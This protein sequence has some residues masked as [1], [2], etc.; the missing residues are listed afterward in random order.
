M[1]GVTPRQRNRRRAPKSR[2]VIS[3]AVCARAGR[4]VVA[5]QL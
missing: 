2:A 3:V 5:S 4:S 1:G